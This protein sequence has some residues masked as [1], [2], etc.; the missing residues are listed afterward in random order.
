M[1]WTIQG[2][3]FSHTS[4]TTLGAICGV[5]RQSDYCSAKLRSRLCTKQSKDLNFEQSICTIICLLFNSCTFPELQ[6]SHTFTCSRSLFLGHAGHPVYY[7]RFPIFSRDSY[8]QWHPLVS[9]ALGPRNNLQPAWWPWTSRSRWDPTDWNVK[10]CVN[11][12]SDNALNL[13]VQRWLAET[14]LSVSMNSF[15]CG[16]ISLIYL[17]PI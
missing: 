7:C 5:C 4:C 10:C 15:I 9:R 12:N 17:S 14:N 8:S 13:L 2:L 11:L 1:T 6:Q 16:V 3:P